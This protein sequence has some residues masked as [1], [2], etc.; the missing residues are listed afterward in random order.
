MKKS[1]L[2]EFIKSEIINEL[3]AANENAA[4][5][6]KDTEE[7]TKAV[8]DLAKA[9]EEAGLTENVGL[10][11]QILEI[12]EVNGLDAMDVMEAIGQQFGVAFEFGRLEEAN[13]G[14]ADLEEMGYEAGEEAFNMHFNLEILK[15]APDMNS[16]RKGFVQAIIDNASGRMFEE[17]LA[18]ENPIQE[19]AKIAGDLKSAI[20]KVIQDNPELDR[21][22]LKKAIKADADVIKALGDSSLYD[23]QL[24]KFIAAAKGE[25]EIGKRGRKADPNA[26]RKPKSTSGRRGRP[27]KSKEEKDKESKTVASKLNKSVTTVKGDEPSAKD[28]KQAIG[29]AKQGKKDLQAQEKRKMVKAFVADMKKQGV[30]SPNGKIEDKEKYDAAW[31]V[32]KPEI[33]AA[34]KNIK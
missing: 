10:I 11:N 14:L 12:I 29:F 3:S 31:A 32:T 23:N 20:E 9:K 21:L 30:I 26:V 5:E 1:E 13:I 22:P 25:R 4:E 8:Q 33:E 19:M 7:L 18:E 28:I 6:I 15:N 24:G 27:A 16:Y 2:K 34:V 17:N